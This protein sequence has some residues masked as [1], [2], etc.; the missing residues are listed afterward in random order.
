VAVLGE[1]ARV[2][3]DDPVFTRDF[4]AQDFIDFGLRGSAVQP[5]G[6]SGW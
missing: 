5:G 6:E 2:V 1:L 4:R 3:I